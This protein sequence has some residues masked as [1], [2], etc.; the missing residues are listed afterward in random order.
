MKKK[1]GKSEED[2]LE[3]QEVPEEVKKFIKI[4]KVIDVRDVERVIKNVLK[5][6]IVLANLKGIKNISDYQSTLREFKRFTNLYK[7]NSLLIGEDFLLLTSKD[8]SI[9]KYQETQQ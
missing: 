8:I 3:I 7:L 2:V 4:E 9:E 1:E 6:K 5:Y